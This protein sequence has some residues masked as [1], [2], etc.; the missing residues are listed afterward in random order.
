MVENIP[1]NRV[2]DN[3]ADLSER[4]ESGKEKEAVAE[5]EEGR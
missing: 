2:W 1:E 5:S 3:M 4:Q